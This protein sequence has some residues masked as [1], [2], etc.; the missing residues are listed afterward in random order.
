MVHLLKKFPI[1]SGAFQLILAVVE[2]VCMSMFV[3]WKGGTVQHV[4]IHMGEKVAERC[5]IIRICQ[6]IFKQHPEYE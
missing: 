2:V 1:N 3:G 5:Y 6:F 4:C